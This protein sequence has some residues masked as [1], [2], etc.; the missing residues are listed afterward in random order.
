MEDLVE[1]DLSAKTLAERCEYCHDL[2]RDDASREPRQQWG[3][4]RL[5]PRGGHGEKLGAHRP[6]NVTTTDRTVVGPR[7]RRRD[8]WRY[9][10]AGSR[11]TVSAMPSPFLSIRLLGPVEIRVD[12]E[13]LAVDTRKAVAL[14]AYLAVTGRPA[15]RE[16]IAALLWPESDGAD[17]RGALRRTLSVLNASLGG[18]GLRIDRRSVE[19]G[20]DAVDLDLDA[21]RG[22]LGRAREHAHD[23]S[24]ACDACDA[25]LD[26]A[27]DLDRGPFMDGFSLRDSEPFDEW[28]VTES[29]AS[30]RD[31]AAALERLARSQLAGGHWDR[32]IAAGRRW[33]D[34]DPLHEPAHRLLMTV[35]ASA[36]EEAA[37]VRQYR[38]CVRILEAELGVAPLEETTSL[39]E[40]IRTGVLR[41]TPAAALPG[42]TDAS[43][44]GPA[45]RPEEF[46]AQAGEGPMVGRAA[47]LQRL[48]DAARAID[49]DG[50]VLVIEGE[51]GIGKTR[52]ARA[53]V[54][55]LATDGAVALEARA[56][57]GEAAIPYAPV[58]ELV[59]AGL[60]GRD[61]GSRLALV[62]PEVL[63]EV[64]R[65]LP[66]P[67]VRAAEGAMTDPLGRGRFL[68]A[69]AEVLTALAGGPR[70]GI[71]W[72]D[73]AHWADG[74][75][76]EALA[77]LARRLRGRS[78]GVLVTWRRED[79]VDPAAGGIVAATADDDRASVVTLG[80][81]G[82]NDIE[83]L[84][85]AAMG[86][87]A[88]TAFVDR[89][90]ADSEGLPLYVAEAL[91]SRQVGDGS[92]VPG[93]EA[94][95]R[96]RLATTSELARQ[97]ASAAAVIGRSFDFET[98]RFA[99]GRSEEETVGALEELDRRGFIREVTAQ[100][101]AELRYDFTHAS[102][103]NVAYGA[104]GLA[105][106]RLLHGRVA[107]S[108]GTAAGGREGGVR[109]P[110]IAYHERLAGRTTRAAE[111]HRRAGDHARRVYANAEA[112]E[113]LEAALALGHPDVAELHEA[114][115]QVLTLLG[116]YR[117]A[118]DH[119]ETAAALADVDRM[120]AIEHQLGKVHARRGAW[121]QAEAHLASALD[122]VSE[123][124]PGRRSAILADESAV[125]HRRGDAVA[126]EH[127]AHEAL[128]VAVS[129]DDRPAIAR[130]E[131]V[132]GMLARRREDLDAARSHLERA[133][134][135][136]D[137]ATDPGLRVGA[138]NTLALV[139][140]DSGDRA[141]A[142]DLTIEA[143]AL[144]E[145][146]GDRHRQAA[147]EN[148]LS[149]LLHADGRG[150]ESM[151]HLKRAVALFA[152]IA[153][154][155]DEPEPEIW[156]LVEW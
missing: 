25:V 41:Q 88:S 47:E 58:A 37:A 82:R 44:S 117:A 20:A 145:R 4:I 110:L 67:G 28:Q 53:L 148:N 51:P 64:A 81:L 89:L 152:E 84:A 108:L 151:E 22:L 69:V 146:I 66:I 61:A 15:S 49:A 57:G 127:A 104:L 155:P 52:L 120:A 103:R 21:F 106:R 10:G 93:V 59:R 32:A 131:D 42:A 96:D 12:S 79:L 115:G 122:V 14:L 118:I 142:I 75:T 38:E 92:V 68:E 39:Y 139:L 5:V 114:L 90:V 138:L 29:E 11:G 125:A 85:R 102:L 24:A 129:A 156:K 143:L 62:R 80:R 116:D 43:P 105:R 109:W 33:L 31:L 83:A 34:L 13:P 77:F 56:Y 76:L 50:R 130:A 112:R 119:L 121:D 3:P 132:L 136:I 107:E 135:A 1:V 153:G 74:P 63:A 23:P 48:L 8:H 35:Y 54:A 65:L 141:T 87:E 140:A 123:A 17:A 55:Q 9:E 111:A 2:S 124:N 16:S 128:D 100:E 71:L 97:V 134:A 40:A 126:A 70:P 60:A 98:V 95:V 7:A 6:G 26:E 99:S 149:D 101:R 19:L 30:R 86:S 94:L 154:E 46:T 113:H 18:R 78:I 133:L 36:S 72:L 150:E 45:D 147:L 73:D 27:L 144:C 137:A 91:A